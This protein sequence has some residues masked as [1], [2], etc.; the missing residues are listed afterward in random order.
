MHSGYAH[1]SVFQ[2]LAQ[3]LKGRLAK[4][5][6]FIEKQYAVMAQGHLARLR[7]RAAT[8]HAGGGYGMMRAAKRPALHKAGIAPE[9]SGNAVYLRDLER[10]LP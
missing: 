5:R 2:G 9:Q 1:F 3:D 4:F 7:D 6:Q 10:L 8:D